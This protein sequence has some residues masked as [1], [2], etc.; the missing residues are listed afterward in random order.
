MKKYLVLGL[1]GIF[2]LSACAKDQNKEASPAASAESEQTETSTA[3]E[4]Q[5]SS[6]E[7]TTSIFQKAVAYRDE[8]ECK[9]IE[10][11]G[12]QKNCIETVS[13]LKEQDSSYSNLPG[14]NSR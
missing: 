5:P 10:D 9:K 3:P 1:V 8:A 12:Q 6:V 11:A 14:G 4:N 7:V 13:K 2:L